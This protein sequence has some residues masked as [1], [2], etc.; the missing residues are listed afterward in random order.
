MNR[1]LDIFLNALRLGCTSFGGPAAHLGYFHK[2]YVERNRWLDEARFSDIVALCQFL[3]GPA[4][5]QVG[6]AVGTLRGGL[7]GGFL[8]WLGFTLPSAVLMIAFALGLAQRGDLGGAAWLRG[9]KIAAVAV[10]ADAVWRL[11]ARLC[12]DAPRRTVALLAAMGMLL[13]TAAWMQL[14]L[15]AAG[16]VVGAIGFRALVQPGPAPD[17]PVVTSRPR[18][19]LGAAALIVFGGLLLALPVIAV[20]TGSRVAEIFDSFYRAG[21]LVFGGGHVV[22]PLL[23]TGVVE[24]GWVDADRFLAG[25]GAAQ[26]L[27]GPLFAFAAYL[28]ASFREAPSG[29]AGGILALVAIYLPSWLLVTGILPFWDRLRRVPSAQAMLLGTNAVV[30]G[31]LLAALYDPVWRVAIHGPR[32]VV[33]LLLA[34]GL[35]FVAK[36]PAWAVVLVAAGAG[37]LLL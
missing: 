3:P 14:V 2:A 36:A 10:V 26:A 32:D 5:S 35:L 6:Y 27:P 37:Q 21:S 34:A 29:I 7:L 1:H 31:L 18:P 33:V 19:R 28:G 8:A 13:A 23:Q 12:P 4:S 20:E 16:A 15:L 9:L 25:Y 24:P 11:G 17:Q 22:L 30:V